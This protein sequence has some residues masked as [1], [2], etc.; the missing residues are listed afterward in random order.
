M[1]FFVSG[2]VNVET[3]LRIRS[4]PVAY[5]PID[6]PFF[7]INTGIAGVGFNVSM[8]AKVLGDNITFCS[9]VGK[10]HEA[11]RIMHAFK[12]AGV[13]GEYI[14]DYL[15]HTPSSVILYEPGNGGKRQ[16]YCDL[17]DIQDKSIDVAAVT[18]AIE[19][20][21]LCVLCNINFNRALLPIAK[22]LGK[23][24]STDVHVI[25]DIYDPFNRDFMLNADILFLSDEELPC[26]PYDFLSRLKNEYSAK[27]IVI[28]LGAD[29]AIMYDRQNDNITQ[30]PAVTLGGV[31]NT[32][33]AGDALFTSFNHYYPKYGAVEALKRAEIFTALKIQHDG[34]AI[35]FSDENRVEEVYRSYEFK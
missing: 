12:I 16:V 14:F 5:Y 10:D 13:S 15:E 24:I 6:Y 21:D 34:G 17:K 31:I 7:G 11:R 4:F 2:L 33:G 25:N 32:V 23:T 35:G 29:G 22:S 20:A 3:N 8:A 30:L 18:P 27:V 28:G 1:N 9:M 26:S 19:S